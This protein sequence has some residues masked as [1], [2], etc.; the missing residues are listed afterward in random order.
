MGFKSRSDWSGGW[1]PNADA[2]NAPT[3]ALLRADN[4]V[5]DELG[6]LALRRGSAKIN[7]SPL[8][9]V[10]VHS[11]FTT[12]LAG[13]RYRMVG[14]GNSVYANSASILGGVAGSGDIAFGFHNG[15]ILFA[16]STTKKKF[17]GATVRNWGIAMTGGVPTVTPVDPDGKL[18]AT[19]A[20]GESPAWTKIESAAGDTYFQPNHYDAADPA[21][22]FSGAFSVIPHPDT[23]RAVYQK[24]FA[25]PTDF[26]AYDAGLLG[27]DDDTISWYIY[28]ADWNELKACV[29]QVDVDDG[30]FLH[31][32]YESPIV[33][34]K[35][36]APP[37]TGRN[38]ADPLPPPPPVRNRADVY[39]Y[40]RWR[41][42]RDRRAL[43]PPT[44]GS[45]SGGTGPGAAW[46][47]AKFT[48]GQFTRQGS[49][50]G[51]DWTTVKAIRI[52]AQMKTINMQLFIEGIRISGGAVV[53]SAQWRYVYV[54]NASGYQ[55]LSAPSEPS[56][57]ATFT[58]Q[59]AT[60]SIPGDGSRDSQVNEVWV[61]RQDLL[62][63]G[64]FFRVKTATVSGTGGVTVTDDVRSVIAQT[65]NIPL[66]IDNE[67]PPDNIIAIVGP[68]YDRTLVLTSD[69]MLHPSRKLD[70]DAF[71][72]GQAIDVCGDDETPYWML[73]ALTDIYVGTSKDI[74]R[75]DGTGAEHPDGSIDYTLRP[76]SMDHRPLNAGLAHEG[77]QI[78]FFSDDGWRAM[79]GG[80]SSSLTGMTSLLYRGQTRHEVSPVNVAGGR[81]RAALAG[82]QLVAITPEGVST[83]SSGVLYR[84]VFAGPR[85]YRHVYNRNWRSLYREPDGTLIAGDDGGHVLVLDTG[86]EDEGEGPLTVTCWT[87]VD[88][89]DL[90]YQR[91][92]AGDFT[93]RSETGGGTSHLAVHLNGSDTAVISLDAVRTT[94]GVLA[95]SL[96]DIPI[97]KQIQIRIT[98]TLPSFHLYDFGLQFRERPIPIAGRVFDILGGSHGVKI[99]SGFVFRG[100]T[101]G[102]AR[103]ITPFLDGV[104]TDQTFVLTTSV[105]EPETHTLRF[106]EAHRATDIGFAVDCEVEIDLWA[107]IV[108]QRQP[109]GVLAWDSGPIDLGDQELVWLREMLLK[110]RAGADLVITPWFDGT[111]YPTVVAPVTPDTDTVLRV[112][113]GRAYVGRQPRLVVTSC[114]PFYPYWVRCT[115]RTTGKSSQKPVVTVPFT[116]ET[117]SGG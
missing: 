43:A 3:T 92:K 115:R 26:T 25:S 53:G 28:A 17:D 20:E 105:E 76:L 57:A 56:V 67:R 97:L 60:V 24:T 100:N 80:G 103:L 16:R 106:T 83:S 19:G 68:H 12:A 23:L 104:A 64:I 14:A 54:R 62:T 111:R 72:A 81:F 70:P 49:A 88:D 47:Q 91:K 102:E 86:T 89:L 117:G 2:V 45:G 79:Q 95:F 73:R 65:I 36:L 44:G 59:A 85:W 74:Y 38:P 22:N 5:L 101:F 52:V 66:Q 116:L 78:V 32:F 27:T 82:G 10:D 69:G 35:L 46:M 11:L 51:K 29:L 108:T 13:T 90:P 93:W 98:G 34:G 41:Q 61:Y 71:S 77:D 96:A 4:L 48:R 42:E 113:V 58:G 112:P 114:E 84:H 55:A 6:V 30:T 63:E 94:M 107:P 75:L 40:H 9:E 87:K 8:A 33:D 1:Q 7:A 110:V 15:Q 50:N 37:A 18:F 31:E 109:V 39:R 99:L 21:Y